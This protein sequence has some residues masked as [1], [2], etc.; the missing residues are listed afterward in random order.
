MVE[1][2]NGGEFAERCCLPKAATDTAPTSTPRTTEA[3]IQYFLS[4]T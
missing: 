4:D 2:W 1:G 3:V